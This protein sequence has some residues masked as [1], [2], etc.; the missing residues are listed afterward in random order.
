MKAKLFFYKRHY[1]KLQLIFEQ[2]WRIEKSNIY[3]RA[4]PINSTAKLKI[5]TVHIKQHLSNNLS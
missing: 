4:E 5:K 3:I 2:V 1:F